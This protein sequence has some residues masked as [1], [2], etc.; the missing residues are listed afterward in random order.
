MKLESVLL[1]ELP[2]NPPIGIVPVDTKTNS[3]A[4]HQSRFMKQL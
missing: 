1:V 3:L 4:V 2:N